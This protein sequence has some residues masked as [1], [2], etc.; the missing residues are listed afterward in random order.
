MQVGGRS[1]A[2]QRGFMEPS[3]D[4]SPEALLG[5]LSV[6]GSIPE[7]E[8]Y[9]CPFC[10]HLTLNGKCQ[11]RRGEV[12]LHVSGLCESFSDR[13]LTRGESEKREA[14]ITG[15]LRIVAEQ[16]NTKVAALLKRE[17]TE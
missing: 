6:G 13:Y 9:L 2:H 17:E 11:K 10:E 8:I 12:V 16:R 7:E 4:D 15:R 3:A 5:V 14:A 1:G